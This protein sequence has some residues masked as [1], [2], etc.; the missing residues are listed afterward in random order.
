[1]SEPKDIDDLNGLQLIDYQFKDP[2]WLEQALTH[3][4]FVGEGVSHNE[5]LEFLGDAVLD[6]VLA[7][8]L[9]K[10]FDAEDEGDLSRRRAS[11]VNESE[12]AAVANEL[13]LGPRLRLGRSEL[14]SG[15][16]KKP[17]ILASAFEALVGALYLDGGFEA[18]S[19]V[20]SRIFSSRLDENLLKSDD[21]TQFQEA[22]QSL[23]K[24]TPRYRTI[25]EIGPSHA[26]IFRVAVDVGGEEWAQGEGPSK[27]VAEQAAARQALEK[28]KGDAG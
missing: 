12:L 27:K 18:A 24:V 10:K 7:E 5:K 21:K 8:L 2:R 20:V 15:G 19:R 6:L 26:R 22:I 3:K 28:I 23:V 11:L 4:S 25:A 14:I 9:L 13:G 17:R 1:M 16:D